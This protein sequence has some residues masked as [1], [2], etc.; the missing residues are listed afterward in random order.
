MSD[1][2]AIG[3]KDDVSSKGFFSKLMHGDFGLAK[4]YWLYGVAASYAGSLLSSLIPSLGGQLVY[5]T[6]WLAYDVI[7]TI[8]IWRAANRYD[9]RRAW[10]ILAKIGGLMG[11]ALMFLAWVGVIV[12]LCMD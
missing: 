3:M 4:T 5:M 12:V 2:T 8:G 10:A 9:G 11:L 6:L 7:L 1:T